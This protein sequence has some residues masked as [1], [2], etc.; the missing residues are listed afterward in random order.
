MQRSG[1]GRICIAKDD[2]ARLAAIAAHYAHEY[3]PLAVPLLRKLQAATLFEPD[4]LPD[5]IVSMNAF[6]RYRADGGP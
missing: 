5:D 4:E 6:V 2:H 3:H 1:W